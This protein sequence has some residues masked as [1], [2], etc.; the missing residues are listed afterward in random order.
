M[1]FEEVP[2][3]R[4]GEKNLNA[5]IGAII[6]LPFSMGEKKNDQNGVMT[7]LVPGPQWPLAI[8]GSGHTHKY[9]RGVQANS[10]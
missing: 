4:F 1:I 10:A 2:C 6:N 8:H 7:F 3:S 9:S 5:L